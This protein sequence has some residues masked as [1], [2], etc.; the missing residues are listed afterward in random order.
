MSRCEVRKQIAL[1]I[2]KLPCNPGTLS[3]ENN[4]HP[5][6]PDGGGTSSCDSARDDH[7]LKRVK[8]PSSTK[9]FPEETDKTPEEC[10]ECLAIF[11]EGMHLR[12]LQN[13]MKKK[14]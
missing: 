13:I 2:Q 6:P 11:S 12:A 8:K 3:D 9:I 14:I 7:F 1:V 4:L 10:L 5:G